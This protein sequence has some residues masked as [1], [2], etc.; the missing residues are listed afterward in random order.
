MQRLVILGSA[1]AGKS[2]LATVLGGMLGLPV[3]HLDRFYWR[4]GW[5]MTPLEEGDALARAALAEPS[6]VMDG[7][8]SRTVPERLQA[9]DTVI[10]LDLPTWVCLWRILQRR[11]QYHGRI[12]PDLAPGC[13]EK[14]DWEFVQWVLTFR[15]RKRKEIM[16]WLEQAQA[17]GKRVELL[18]THR[19][20]RRFVAG[21]DLASKAKLMG[22]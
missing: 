11:V 15:R 17:A 1:G 19:E 5:V 7:N 21:L 12:R 22:H 6:W 14:L 2:T 3:V 18:Q 16:G 4:P 8:W 20:V 9:C 10:Y 13:Y